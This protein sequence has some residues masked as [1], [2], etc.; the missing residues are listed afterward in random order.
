MRCTTRLLYVNRTIIHKDSCDVKKIWKRQPD[1]YVMQVITRRTIK[2]FHL[3]NHYVDDY[4]DSMDDVHEV[5]VIASKVREIH[6]IA[7]FEMRK[8]L[9]KPLEVITALGKLM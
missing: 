3:N 8:Y 7:G 6:M 9:S 4:L 2:V 1:V 5:I